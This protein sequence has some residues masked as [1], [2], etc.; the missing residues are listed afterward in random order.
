SMA[1]VEIAKPS[2]GLGW[3]AL[4]WQYFESLDKIKS[5]ANG[6]QLEKELFLKK[7]TSG[8]PQLI[9]IT[10]DTPIA[11]GDVV[12][13]RL[14]IRSDRDMQFMHLKD[15][16]ASGFEPINVHSSYKWQGGLGYY[17]GTRDAA[18]NFFFDRMPKGTYVFE[19]DVRANNAGSFSNGNTVLQSVYAPELRTHSEGIRVEIKANDSE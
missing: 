17:E 6:V 15:L 16:R 2:A 7:N 4:Y 5:S 18:T 8:A 11:L 12:T 1:R 3:G 14:I 13:V 19:Y 9:R 10:E